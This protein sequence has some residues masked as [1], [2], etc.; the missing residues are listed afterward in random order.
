MFCL[1]GGGHLTNLSM[2]VEVDISFE[3]NR[4]K[5]FCSK[6]QDVVSEDIVSGGAWEP[7]ITKEIANALKTAAKQRQLQSPAMG[8]FLDIGANLGWHSL[9]AAAAGY[10][11]IGFEP[12]MNNER[13]QRS[14]IC[15]NPGFMNRM[16]LHSLLLSNETGNNCKIFSGN[17]NRGNGMVRCDPNYQVPDGFSLLSSDANVMMLDEFGQGLEDVLVLKMDIE[18]H[19]PFVIKG[20]R[21]VLLNLHIPY[22]VIEWNW[23]FMAEKGFS[24]AEL[25]TILESFE[26]AG[27]A[28]K[29]D[30]FGG[31]TMTSEQVQER[32]M[33]IDNPDHPLS[34]IASY[35]VE[36]FMVH[37]NVK[38]LI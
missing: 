30:G 34:G 16:T 17:D 22:M 28:L 18:G 23:D 36:L 37:N 1:L 20:G 7:G 24:H 38:G 3:G 21:E 32:A 31:A 14:S 33:N 29:V 13:L 11:V 5:M 4:F 15:A 26:Q 6:K 35:G 8:V 12:V 10:R 27:Y 2:A 9:S 19:E 25:L